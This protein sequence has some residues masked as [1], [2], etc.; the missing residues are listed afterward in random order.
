M[1][2]ALNTWGCEGGYRRDTFLAFSGSKET[3]LADSG[4]ITGPSP[5]PAAPSAVF[6]AA[7]M[8]IQRKGMGNAP[9]SQ[10]ETWGGGGEIASISSLCFQSATKTYALCQLN[11]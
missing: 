2:P 5:I 4:Q 1:I 10:S 9:Q 6:V 8:D 3:A 11:K 7:R